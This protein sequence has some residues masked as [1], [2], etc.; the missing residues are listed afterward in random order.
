MDLP[1]KPILSDYQQLIRELVITRGFD[2]ETV[3]E[4]FTL[5]VEEVGELAKAIR[6]ANGQKVDK[7][8][9][10][11]DVEEEAADF[12][13]LLIDI[14]NRLDIDLEKAFRAKETKNQTRQ[15]Q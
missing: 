14:C 8:S 4:V 6:K 5:L 11:H 7:K 3:P 1:S 9:K 10:Q 15:W 13:W 2:K 12:F